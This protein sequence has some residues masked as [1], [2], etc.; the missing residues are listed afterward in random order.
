M[1]KVKRCLMGIGLGNIFRNFLWKNKKA[2][3]FFTAFY[4][5]YKNV[6]KLFLKW[7]ISKC[8]K[9]TRYSNFFLIMKENIN[10]CPNSISLWSI[11]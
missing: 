9:N 5:S 1:K 6:I 11:F 2:T 3:V 8:P 7:F 10:G 4:I